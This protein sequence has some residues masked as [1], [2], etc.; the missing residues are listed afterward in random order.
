MFRDTCAVKITDRNLEVLS[1]DVNV[2][3]EGPGGE[4]GRGEESAF[5]QGNIGNPP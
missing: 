2:W 1:A 5:V 4:L 3:S